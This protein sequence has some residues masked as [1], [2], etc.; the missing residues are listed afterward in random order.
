MEDIDKILI[1]SGVEDIN[2]IDMTHMLGCNYDSVTNHLDLLEKD[3]FIKGRP[4]HYN[5][6]DAGF[7][8]IKK[9]LAEPDYTN[10]DINSVISRT[11]NYFIT[12]GSKLNI[13]NTLK[14]DQTPHTKLTYLKGVLTDI[15]TETISPEHY[16]NPDMAMC[17]WR[18]HEASVC[19]SCG[20]DFTRTFDAHKARLKKIRDMNSFH[21]I[22]DS[23]LFTIFRYESIPYMKRLRWHF[24]MEP[25]IE[26]FP[27]LSHEIPSSHL[28][29]PKS[30]EL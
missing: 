20:F 13:I 9:L 15:Y 8:R 7:D 27:D 3:G 23:D 2:P 29:I 12:H 11:S 17:F 14:T 19:I 22:T 18:N 5:V 24:G 21:Y 10:D 4:C 6:T 28:S 25:D 26:L 16:G 1:A 30:T